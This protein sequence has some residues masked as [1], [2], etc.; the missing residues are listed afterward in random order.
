MSVTVHILRISWEGWLA[1]ATSLR[2][3]WIQNDLSL[4]RPLLCD[5][6]AKELKIVQYTPGWFARLLGSKPG[7]YWEPSLES[8]TLAVVSGVS[9][10]TLWVHLADGEAVATQ[11]QTAGFSGAAAT[12][13]EAFGKGYDPRDDDAIHPGMEG[14]MLLAP[15]DCAV[16]Q[17]ALEG[18]ELDLR[19]DPVLALRS[20]FVDRARNEGVAIITD[21]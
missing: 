17:D 12:L 16:V 14:L 1:A 20:A 3:A 13:F 6:E 4:V 19:A 18:T 5:E 8:V 11:L 15:S 9:A 2:Q 21:C 7:T 10:E